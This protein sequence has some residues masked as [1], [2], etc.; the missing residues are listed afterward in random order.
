MG[1]NYVFVRVLSLNAYSWF[2][3]DGLN[4]KIEYNKDLSKEFLVENVSVYFMNNSS[5]CLLYLY[6]IYRLEKTNPLLLNLFT[7]HENKEN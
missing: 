2:R 3:L 4:V 1:L 5:Y 7:D 6:L